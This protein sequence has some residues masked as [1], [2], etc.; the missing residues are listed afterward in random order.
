MNALETSRLV[1]R[2]A[3]PGDLDALHAIY[4]DPEA[5]RYWAE[6]PHPSAE[7]TQGLLNRMIA[8]SDPVT[9][10]FVLTRDGKV[11]GTAGNHHGTEVGFM[12]ARSCW[13]QGLMREA[14]EAVTVG[15][16]STAVRTHVRPDLD[17]AVLALLKKRSALNDR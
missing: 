1:L 10:Y 3:R 15:G 2:T 5:M 14:I 8:G 4:S 16:D 17:R 6:P 13:G 12:L 9:R 11:I 7:R